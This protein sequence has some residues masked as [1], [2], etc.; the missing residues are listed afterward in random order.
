MKRRMLHVLKLVFVQ[1][2]AILSWERTGV[3]V[4]LDD[5]GRVP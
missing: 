2:S 4:S 1:K 5:F 3:V